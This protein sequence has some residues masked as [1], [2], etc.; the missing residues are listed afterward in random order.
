MPDYPTLIR[1]MTEKENKTATSLF[2]GGTASEGDSKSRPVNFFNACRNIGLELVFPAKC[3]I[4]RKP[5][6]WASLG[7]VC[8]VCQGKIR[9]IQEPI[10]FICGHPILAEIGNVSKE[11]ITCTS[12]KKNV[13]E[14]TQNRSVF[15]YEGTLR[16]LVH[17][18]K[19]QGKITIGKKLAQ[20]MGDYCRE[21]LYFSSAECIVP[22]PLGIKKLR[23]REFNQSFILAKVVGKYLKVPVYPFALKK[24]K[25]P[26]SQMELSRQDRMRNVRG[27][28]MVR[29]KK[30]IN[31]KEV[32]LVDDVFT[33]GATIRECS[34]VL[35]QHGVKKVWALTLARTIL[36]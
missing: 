16:Q 13:S 11:K 20:L 27:A 28:F 2:G 17:F 31:R 15:Y 23:H 30:Q 5:L 29:K 24:V 14:F 12:C 25:E 35:L 6:E 3:V 26:A 21:G 7:S 1:G 36:H 22:V 8:L 33:T 34:R 18:F 4:C 32:L 10:C 9:P 19:Y